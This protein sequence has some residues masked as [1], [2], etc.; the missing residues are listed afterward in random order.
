MTVDIVH[1][2]LKHY[3]CIIKHYKGPPED[4]IDVVFVEVVPDKPITVK[5]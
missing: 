4:T 1:Q 3:E 2:S 5:L